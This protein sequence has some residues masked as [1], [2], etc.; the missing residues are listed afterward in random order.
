MSN[1]IHNS[2]LIQFSINC[3]QNSKKSDG[4]QQSIDDTMKNQET[5]FHANIILS[6][7]QILN[8]TSPLGSAPKL[9]SY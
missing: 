3:Q 1:A 2:D 9:V 6:Q 4:A 5:I 7:S 8:A